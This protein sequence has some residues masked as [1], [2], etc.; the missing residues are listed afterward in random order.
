MLE[1]I[2]EFFQCYLRSRLDRIESEMKQIDSLPIISSSLSDRLKTYNSLLHLHIQ[3]EP[4]LPIS[5]LSYEGLDELHRT[6]EHHIL[7][8]K[9][10]FP[11]IDRILPTLWSDANRDIESLADRL[12]VPYLLWD[13]LS[14]H[15]IEHHG[16]KN[17]VENISMSLQDQG[18]IQIVNEIGTSN[19]LVFLRPLWLGDLLSC[20]FHPTFDHQFGHVHMDQI[21]SLWRH[22]LSTSE[23]FDQLCFLLMRFLLIAYPKMRKKQL[24]NLLLHHDGDNEM[25]FEEIIIPYYL[26]YLEPD[27]RQEE[28]ANFFRDLT[29]SVSVTY[30]SLRLPQGLFHRYSVSAIFKLDIVYVKH[31]KNFLLGEHEAKKV[32]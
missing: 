21:R 8:Q 13:D 15:I 9:K 17:L 7:T 20:L 2:N 4:C 6:I 24:R 23:S 22:F 27:G 3:I 1:K 12:P 26:P 31:W 18:K 28:K 32:Q 11:N 30:R 25:K 16:L 19:R 10:I 29:H 14:T 5:S